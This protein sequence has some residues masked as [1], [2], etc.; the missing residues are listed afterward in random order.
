MGLT[1]AT[2]FGQQ[3]LAGAR[4]TLILGNTPVFTVDQVRVVRKWS[5]MSIWPVISARPPLKQRPI[6]W[7]PLVGDHDGS[8]ARPND[9]AP[10]P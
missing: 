7:V 3:F 10:C 9:Q 6:T 8:A 1:A 2:N 4:T 5:R